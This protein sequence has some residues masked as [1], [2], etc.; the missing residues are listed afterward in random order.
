MDE[1][2]HEDIQNKIDG[3]TGVLG[4]LSALFPALTPIAA[5][6]GVGGYTWKRM[7]GTVTKYKK[8]S[9]LLVQTLEHIKQNDA[10]TWA[11]IKAEIQA[12]HP[13]VDFKGQ[14]DQ[15]KAELAKQHKLAT[16]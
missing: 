10:A 13:A 15:I 2:S 1:K 7:K 16:V 9:E 12:Q 8:P 4:G 3:A 6:A 5:A 14:I 11:K